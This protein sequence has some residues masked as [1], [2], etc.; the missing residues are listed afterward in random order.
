MKFPKFRFIYIRALLASVTSIR[1]HRRIYS[2]SPSP[3][4]FSLSLS[5]SLT[6][7][8]T[9]TL[10]GLFFLSFVGRLYRTA[11]N[12]RPNVSISASLCNEQWD[13]FL[14]KKKKRR[15]T[16]SICSSRVLV[17]RYGYVRIFSISW[18]NV[19]SIMLRILLT[20]VTRR[21]PRCSNNVLVKILKT[22]LELIWKLKLVGLRSSV[23]YCP[24]QNSTKESRESWEFFSR[25][26][27]FP[28]P[29]NSES[30]GKVVASLTST[31][32][33]WRKRFD[34]RGHVNARNRR[35]VQPS[36][37]EESNLVSYPT[38]YTWTLVADEFEISLSGSPFLD[39]RP[40]RRWRRRARARAMGKSDKVDWNG[41]E[42]EGEEE[43]D[44]YSQRRSEQ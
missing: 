7:T 5:L 19:L 4:A 8:H 15:K 18:N 33:K 21:Q 28:A 40:F 36:V 29:L 38:R 20:C 30:I 26:I 27:L 14:R 39:L 3:S 25:E 35:R 23:D 16:R 1:S 2:S 32:C 24:F 22:S 17:S 9:H 13:K 42:K 43:E 37:R 6:H 34:W 31:S 12:V 41:E 44:G 10:T 11:V